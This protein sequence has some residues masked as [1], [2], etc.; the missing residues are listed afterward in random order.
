MDIPYARKKTIQQA[1]SSQHAQSAEHCV[2][3]LMPG[4]T[5]ANIRIEGKDKRQIA[6]LPTLNCP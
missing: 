1:T 5:K 3:T 4:K 6:S 2:P